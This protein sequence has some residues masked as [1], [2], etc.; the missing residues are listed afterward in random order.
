M[1]QL[2]NR[3]NNIYE[4]VLESEINNMSSETSPVDF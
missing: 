1:R 3:E 2:I 4:E